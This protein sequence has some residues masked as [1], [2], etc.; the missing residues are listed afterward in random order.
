[1]IKL[2]NLLFQEG[3]D[4]VYFDNQ[5]MQFQ[6]EKSLTFIIYNDK[7]YSQWSGLHYEL[8]KQATGKGSIFKSSKGIV[9]GRLYLYIG[10]PVV[11]FSEFSFDWCRKNI[12]RYCNMIKQKYPKIRPLSDWYIVINEDRLQY[13]NNLQTAD[14]K[15]KFSQFLKLNKYQ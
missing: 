14:R 15:G 6:D 5:K 3:T 1:M 13:K 10:H 2:L 9:Y 12:I 7:L 8:Q 4:I 11:V